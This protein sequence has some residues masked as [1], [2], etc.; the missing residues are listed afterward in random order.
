ML[1]VRR[2]AAWYLIV[3]LGDG[4]LQLVRP[5][6][7]FGATI[8]GQHVLHGCS[9]LPVVGTPSGRRPNETSVQTSVSRH[10]RGAWRQPNVIGWVRATAT[11]AINPTQAKVSKAIRARR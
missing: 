1:V 9:L 10:Q 8:G 11:P 3:H 6:R 2:A 4:R 7:T 5:R